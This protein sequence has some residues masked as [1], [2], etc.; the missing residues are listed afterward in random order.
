MYIEVAGFDLGE[1][2]ICH[3]GKEG[4]KRQCNGSVFFSAVR[5]HTR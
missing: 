1:A 3:E 5:R 2:L 4:K